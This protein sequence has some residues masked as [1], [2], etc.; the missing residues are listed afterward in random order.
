MNKKFIQEKS[1]LAADLVNSVDE[2]YKLAAFQVV[3]SKL[4]DTNKIDKHVTF[5]KSN[6][7]NANHT[8]NSA[9]IKKGMNEL[10][11]KCKI[12][13]NELNDIFVFEDNVTRLV[14]RLSGTI[15]Y[16]QKIAIKCILVWYKIVFGMDWVKT[17]DLNNC[18]RKSKISTKNLNR[19]FTDSMF[20]TQGHSNHM[21]YRIRESNIKE[22]YPMIK[23]LSKGVPNE[24][25]D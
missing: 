11:K 4:L 1:S 2:F 25:K 3:F 10:A 14:A 22:I 6:L 24:N 12:T 19:I 16:K 23:N 18:L 8:S 21:K 20:L 13:V 7:K 15:P 5:D 17:T 9:N